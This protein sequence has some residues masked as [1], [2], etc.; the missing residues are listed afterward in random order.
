MPS[1]GQILALSLG[2]LLVVCGCRPFAD[3]SESEPSSGPAPMAYLKIEELEP[4]KLPPDQARIVLSGIEIPVSL[5]S[6]TEGRNLTLAW[7]TADGALVEEENYLV[8][9]D[10]FSLLALPGESYAPAI[11]LVK[12]PMQVGDTL[13]WKGQVKVGSNE[14]PAEA[15][16][17]S[18]NESV[19]LAN[20]K[21]EALRVD[22][23]L[24]YYPQSKQESKKSLT[25]W[26]QP[27]GGLVKRE[28]HTASMREPRPEEDNE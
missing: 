3:P 8:T 28:F 17:I 14:A 2:V 20:G 1:P 9:S 6:E 7:K 26:F 19:N 27:H 4:A 18:K 21:Y 5:H 25:F 16:V 12:F 24:I 10:S 13:Q 15:V 11:P 23:Q 22:L